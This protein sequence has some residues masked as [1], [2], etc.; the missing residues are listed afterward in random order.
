M[1]LIHTDNC[2]VCG[3]G[4]FSELVSCRDNLVT[5]EIFTI[6]K[7][8][9]CGFGFTQD[10]PSEDV[11]GKYYEADDYISHSDTH[12][13]IVN[14]LYHWARKMALRSKARLIFCNS[15]L[16]TSGQLLDIGAG[17]GYFLNTM[18]EKGWVVTGI[19]KSEPTRSFAKDKFG[20]NLHDSE[21]LF[22]IPDK[23]KDVVTMWHVLEHV[24]KLNQTVEQI[25]KIL[26]DDGIAVI[27]LPN[28]N[29]YDAVHYKANWAAYD[30]PRHLW[31]FSPSDFSMLAE[32]H[33]FAVKK[34]KPMYFDAFYISMLSEKIRGAALATVVG[35]IAGGWFSFMS[36]FSTCRCSSV[37]YVLRKK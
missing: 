6:L 22:Q 35:L 19:E 2:P 17:T 9:N 8:D 14:T 7:C 31:H 16:Q 13:G 32:K 5:K 11:I 36:L 25:H 20:L 1:A 15:S 24:E 30:V 29:S 21:Y 12:K 28:K 27:A 4:D 37:T 33:G 10:F 23:S 18:Q 3:K 34:M 26:N